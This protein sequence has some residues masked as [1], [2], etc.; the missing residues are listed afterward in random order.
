MA[1]TADTVLV[2]LEASVNAYNANVLS[3]Q[4]NFS[5]AMA[6]I[7]REA[8][9]AT[10]A[11]ASLFKSYIGYQ[12]VSRAASALVESVDAAKRVSN[13]LKIAGLE[14]EELTRVYDALFASA[15]RNA[16]PIEAL[17]QLYG[18]LS[19]VQKELNVT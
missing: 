10:T 15:Q 1:V 14:G 19:L 11:I 9:T 5:R 4:T 18:R 17:A 8:G 6:S 3:A 16:A 13:A 7:R 12:A 2:R